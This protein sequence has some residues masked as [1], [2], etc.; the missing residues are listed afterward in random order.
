MS[1]RHV[2]VVGVDESP[3]AEAAVEWAAN[4]AKS[5][6]AVLIVM[7]S[8][9][10]SALA[11]HDAVAEYGEFLDWRVRNIVEDAVKRAR[12]LLPEADV[13][14][15]VCKGR[16][17]DILLARSERAAMVVVGSRRLGRLES[18]MLGSVGTSVA[19]LSKCPV[20]VVRDSAPPAS[21]AQHVVA[22]IDVTADS[23]DV[24]DFAFDYASRHH[25]PLRVLT[26]VP[27]DPL[28]PR[29][30]SRARMLENA[31]APYLSE[32]TVG[33]QERYPD[34]RLTTEVVCAHSVAE[35]VERSTG[36]SLLV[37]GKHRR[38]PFV[39]SLLGSVSQGVLHHA[40]C[41]VAIVPV[42]RPA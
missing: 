33:W 39:A 4:E 2:I 36:Q 9:E 17:T 42:P 31:S 7:G 26:C 5:Q 18:F 10:L 15:E 20:V 19:A 6:H 27:P 28:T 38:R 30:G 11:E 37:V 25:L 8:Y 22:G 1:S 14:G 21:R 13:I 29:G 3:G 16:A 34:V 35:L 32:A 40:V 41:P 23:Q 12:D 24:L